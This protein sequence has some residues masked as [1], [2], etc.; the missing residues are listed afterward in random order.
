MSYNEG[1]V[2]PGIKLLGWHEEKRFPGLL[3]NSVFLS[4]TH[5]NMHQ[6]ASYMYM[7]Y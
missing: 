5:T 2:E 7:V 1:K 3:E 4:T 6:V